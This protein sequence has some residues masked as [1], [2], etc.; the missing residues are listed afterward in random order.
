MAEDTRHYH[1]QGTLASVHLCHLACPWQTPRP[2]PVL[3]L[4]PVLHT[5]TWLG[6]LAPTTASREGETSSG[7]S[8]LG[9]GVRVSPA[10]GTGGSS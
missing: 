1:P 9:P 5:N 2:V 7:T 10:G 4:L 8:A 3:S 6:F